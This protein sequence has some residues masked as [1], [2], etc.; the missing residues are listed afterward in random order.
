MNSGEILG[1]L[2]PNGAGKS[3]TFNVLTGLI[4]KSTGDVTLKGVDVDGRVSGVNSDVGICPQFN[5]IYETLTV[6]EHLKLFGR[7][8]GLKGNDLKES[9]EYFMK[10]MQLVDYKDR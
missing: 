8:K 4:G 2:G 6:E 7:V 10:I 5:T 3:T 9:I 1:L